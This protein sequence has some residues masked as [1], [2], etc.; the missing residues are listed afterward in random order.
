M[1]KKPE[2]RPKSFEILLKII[3][4]DLKAVKNKNG[5]FSFIAHFHVINNLLLVDLTPLLF[6]HNRPF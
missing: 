4:K 2:I 6:L 5:Q 1:K 3:K